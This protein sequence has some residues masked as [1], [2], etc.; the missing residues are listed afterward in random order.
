MFVFLLGWHALV[1][2][3]PALGTEGAGWL[4]L[5]SIITVLAISVITAWFTPAREFLQQVEAR[6]EQMPRPVDR[7][8]N[9]KAILE[10]RSYL[11][12]E[13]DAE[14]LQQ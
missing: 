9:L 11:P 8:E 14:F 10:S 7:E 12:V 2:Q 1:D 4:L 5:G 3:F 6:R 13:Y